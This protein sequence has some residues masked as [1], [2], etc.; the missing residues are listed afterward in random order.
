MNQ[1]IKEFNSISKADIG[2]VGGKNSSLGEMYNHL[3]AKGIQVPDGF[4]TTAFAFE[5]FLLQNR[6]QSTLYELMQKL[7][8][9]D[10]ANLRELGLKARELLLNASMPRDL[11]LAIISAYKVL[12]GDNY[13]EVAVRSSATAEDLPQASFAGQHESFFKYK[14]GTSIVRCR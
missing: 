6:L 7:D 4:A 5:E 13:F 3:S 2:I 11:E 14:R 12:C 10:F 1:Y 8:R 9:S